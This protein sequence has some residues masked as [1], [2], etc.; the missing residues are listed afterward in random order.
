[1]ATT[2]IVP[3]DGEADTAIARS[4]GVICQTN[5]IYSVGTYRY[6]NINDA[7]TIQINPSKSSL[8][9]SLSAIIQRISNSQDKFIEIN[10]TTAIS[11]KIVK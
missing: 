8:H 2:P 11:I 6:T 4:L 1:M 9:K 10:G 3:H 5:E 7:I